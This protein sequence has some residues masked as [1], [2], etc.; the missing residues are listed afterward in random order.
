MS[1]VL[2][3]HLESHRQQPVAESDADVVVIF[4]HENFLRHGPSYNLPRGDTRMNC[5][6]V[7]SGVQFV[8]TMEKKVRWHRFSLSPRKLLKYRQLPQNA[9]KN[10]SFLGFS[11]TIRSFIP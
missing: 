8:Q 5:L 11:P 9:A 1:V 4:H 6:N 2:R 10:V 7:R 3:H